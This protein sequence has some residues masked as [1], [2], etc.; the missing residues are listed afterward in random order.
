MLQFIMDQNVLLYVC[1]VACVLGVVSQ[2]LLKH[3][4]ERLIS[5]TQMMGEPK[6][7]FLRQLR[8][9]FKNCMHLNEK[10]NDI[11]AFTERSLMD[12]R[13]LRMSL[14]RWYRMGAQALV[15]SLLCCA[16]GAWLMYT[17]G[18]Q[19][20]LHS[21]YSQAGI[22][23]ALLIGLAYGWND[24][25]YYRRALRIRLADYLQNS[26]AV[27]EYGEVDF[28]EQAAKG[29]LEAAASMERETAAQAGR[30]RLRME[31]GETRAQKEKKEM[32]ESLFRTKGDGGETAAAQENIPARDRSRELLR[33][34]D[35]K[36][37]EQIL[38]D[39]LLEILA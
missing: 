30:K 27:R 28:S 22:W 32:K 7:K 15:V 36:E 11:T 26:G 1:G 19:I 20:T 17:D 8:Q 23:S 25:R 13:F 18:T 9:R 4:Y 2:F 24:N 14:H 6:G 39:V 35:P 16:A 5:E 34:M 21:V 38:R 12:Y 31:R 33:Q 10:V 37:K 29:T 3:L